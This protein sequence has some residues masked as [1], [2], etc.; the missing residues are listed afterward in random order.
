MKT[1]DRPA[2]AAESASMGAPSYTRRLRWGRRLIS[3]LLIVAGILSFTYLA[4]SAFVAEQLVYRAPTPIHN[5]PAK[6]G[7]RFAY[8]SFPSREDRLTLN[9][10]FIPGILPNGRLTSERTIVA[11]HGTW[12]NREDT[13]DNLLQLT[14][15]LAKHGFAVLAF[16]MRGM[17]ESQP[18]PLS[19]GYFEQRDV[20]GAVDFLRSGDL[21]FPE[22]GRPRV[23]GGLGI[24]MGAATLLMAASH[25]PAIRAVVSDS[26]YATVVPLIERDL[27]KY[28]VGIIGHA[29]GVLAPSGLVLARLL[30]GIDFF[31]VRPV[32]SVKAVASRP[33]FLIHGATDDYVPVSNFDQLRAAAMS[34]PNANVT[35]W[36]VPKARHAQA[37][38]VARSEYVSRVVGFFDNA[39]GAN[40]NVN[41]AA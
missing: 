6:F 27:S 12:K 13:G 18:A 19:F 38:K 5:T 3:V 9:G 28:Q 31:A 2:V 24:S 4:A 17:G 10:W 32:D 23:I 35:T 37:Y 7:L 15:E 39:L 36:L 21:P 29:P 16:D 11:V 33:L 41:G 34:S 22:L 8:V 30:Y 20:L 1:L 14:A 40:S 25:E 26:A